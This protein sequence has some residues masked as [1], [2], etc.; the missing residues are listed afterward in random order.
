[1]EIYHINTMCGQQSTY[2]P[3]VYTLAGETLE[4]ICDFYFCSEKDTDKWE[5][6]IAAKVY[7]LKKIKI[8]EIRDLK[9]REL[10]KAESNTINYFEDLSENFIIKIKVV[11]GDIKTVFVNGNEQFEVEMKKNGETN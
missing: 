3:E 5:C 2:K 4:C 11:D 10:I 7:G 8:I 1:M 9:N 6:H